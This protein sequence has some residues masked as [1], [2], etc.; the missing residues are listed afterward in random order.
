MKCVSHLKQFNKVDKDMEGVL[1]KEEEVDL[2]L[3]DNLTLEKPDRDMKFVLLSWEKDFYQHICE[4]EEKFVK[5]EKTLLN[6]LS[7]NWRKKF[8]KKG[9][10]FFF[11]IIEWC[12]YV[13]NALVVKNIS[14]S[15]IP[16]YKVIFTRLLR[17][18]SWT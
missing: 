6:I 11:F 10:I 7:Q 8:N 15:K 3:K 13:K 14:W 1:T 16:G 17:I 9:V 12:Q 18:I 2:L 4:L 5:N